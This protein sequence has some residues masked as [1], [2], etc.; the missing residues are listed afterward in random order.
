MPLG[1]WNWLELAKLVV[2][3]LTPIIVVAI[4]IWV[5]RISSRL[6]RREWTSRR[7]IER[8]IDIYDEVAPLLNDIL[9]YFIFV[10]HWKSLTP[11]HIVEIKRLLDRQMHTSSAFFSKQLMDAYLAYMAVCFEEYIRWGVDARLRCEMRRHREAAGENWKEDWNDMFSPKDELSSINQVRG[12]YMTLIE[13]FSSE[14][15]IGDL[16]KVTVGPSPGRR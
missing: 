1:D 11:I 16:S 14:L 13:M 12:A 10:G 5:A 15:Q 4:G 6:E 7:L 3:A 9:V 8:R 2:A